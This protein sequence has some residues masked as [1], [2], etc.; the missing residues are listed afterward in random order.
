MLPEP[1]EQA[2][3]LILR[4]YEYAQDANADP[5]QFAL[6]IRELEIIGLATTDV[7]WLLLKNYASLG[8]ET[9]IPGDTTRSFR[10]IPFTALNRHAYLVVTEQG[11]SH[12]R[13]RLSSES[14]SP[15]PEPHP[16][17]SFIKSNGHVRP[18]WD[19]GRRELRIGPTVV[20]RYRVPAPNQEL[21]L[22]AFEEESWPHSID[23]PLPP[24]LEQD[25]QQRL[26]ATIK[27]LNRSHL[28]PLIR[29]H[30]NGGGEVICWDFLTDVIASISSAQ[31]DG[32]YQ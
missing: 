15:A 6:S 28:A 26:R 12:L 4:A 30:A 19:P 32:I 13:Q 8:I 31:D 1:H 25:C 5:W 23:D 22:Q 17:Q 7:R 29:F 10:T 18:S 21:V 9:T 3:S 16:D 24:V 14:N 11:A 27:S 20:K 2:L